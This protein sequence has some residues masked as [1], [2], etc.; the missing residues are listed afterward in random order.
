MPRPAFHLFAYS[1][2]DQYVRIDG[3][4]HGQH[5]ARNAGQ[6][7]RC[8]KKREAG[9][10]DSD[11]NDERKDREQPEKTVAC[12]HKSRHRAK[13]DNG[14]GFAR[15]DRIRA[16]AWA[17]GPLLDNRE[18]GGKGARFQEQRKPV[19]LLL[20]EMAGD[21]AVTAWDFRTDDWRRNHLIVEDDGE[22]L[23]NVFPRNARESRRAF[24][25][26][27]K[28]DG[29]LAALVVKTC[30]GIRQ[31][32]AAYENL[33]AHENASTAAFLVGQKRVVRRHAAR[34]GV[35]RR[36][37]CVDELESQLR[38]RADAGLDLIGSE[39]RHLDQN[40]VLAI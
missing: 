40:A 11:V 6:S 7:E 9:H 5:H 23:A 38:C 17:D 12:D 25:I 14:R 21:L 30:I 34:F 18:R 39:A 24:A 36:D 16:K 15:F 37:A 31:I 20:A 35:L 27:F 4:A 29:R 22:W 13:A 32:V 19:H 26:Q 8:V 33:L 3:H 28:H 10:D 1:F 2:V